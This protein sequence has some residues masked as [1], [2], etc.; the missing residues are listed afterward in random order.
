MGEKIVQAREQVVKL[1]AEIKKLGAKK[2]DDA[3]TKIDEMNKQIVKL[4]ATS[5]FDSPLAPGVRDASLHVVA[6]KGTHGSLVTYQENAQDIPLEI[7]G[8]PNKPGTLVPRRFLSVLSNGKAKQFT[9]GSGRL[10]CK[11]T[12]LPA[13]A[14]AEEALSYKPDG[15][16]LSNGPGD[17]EPCDYAVSAIKALVHGH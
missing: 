5:G 15:I 13:Q 1:E 3:L 8:N 6:A 2:A 7:R 10:D 17:P 4:K 14:T 9:Q 12:V 11:V 16:F